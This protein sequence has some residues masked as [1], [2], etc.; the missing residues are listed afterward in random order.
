[1]AFAFGFVVGAIC[2]SLACGAFAVWVLSDWTD[3]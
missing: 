1:M 2:A 3:I